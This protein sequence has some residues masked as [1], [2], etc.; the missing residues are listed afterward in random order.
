LSKSKNFDGKRFGGKAEGFDD[1]TK[2]PENPEQAAE[3]QEANKSWWE[4]TPMRYDWR[5]D[6]NV[7]PGGEEYFARID[8]QFFESARH[9]LKSRSRPFDSLIDFAALKDKHVL[10]IGVGHGSHAELIAPH[11]RKYTGI[12]LTEA[13][14][15]M[16]RRRLQ[17]K[18]I[19][20]EIMQMDAEQ[21]KFA[22][23]SFDYIWSWGVI[24]HSSNTRRII[25]EMGRVLRPAGN[26]VVMVY[27]RSP[28]KYYIMDGLI[29]GLLFREYFKLGSLHAVSQA[30]TDGAI[31]R[32][33]TVKQ[34][35]ELVRDK[36]T[37]DRVR[38]TGHK[39]DVIPLPSGRLKQLLVRYIPDALTRFLTDKLRFGSFLVVD[40][41]KRQAH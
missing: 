38:I 21:M 15:E 13:A 20:A 23:E 35:K 36:F 14:S 37:I 7:E 28:W 32:Y 11:C 8:Q 27:Y 30:Q 41:A 10:E 26:A 34:F 19:D 29:K 24:H 31:A 12:D 9:Y 39:T 22:D 33:Y 1:P 5:E 6:L 40:L 25:E 16:T 18:S 2:L 17:I 3:W 4:R